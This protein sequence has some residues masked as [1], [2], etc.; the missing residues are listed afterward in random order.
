MPSLPG[1]LYK[2]SAHV[3][4]LKFPLSGIPMIIK[5]TTEASGTI[6]QKELSGKLFDEDLEHCNAEHTKYVGALASRRFLRPLARSL[7]QSGLV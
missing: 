5:A 6:Y 2:L 7:H 3:K 4:F 1:P